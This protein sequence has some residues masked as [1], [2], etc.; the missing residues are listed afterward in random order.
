MYTV[1]ND[2][3]PWINLKM[4]HII[5]EVHVGLGG[6]GP[7]SDRRPSDHTCIPTSKCKGELKDSRFS[8]AEIQ[9][10]WIH[11]PFIGVPTISYRNRSIVMKIIRTEK[12]YTHKSYA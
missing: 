10:V 3:P 4:P 12:P 11:C 5:G 2:E 1:V 7:F 6:Q 9:E 8:E